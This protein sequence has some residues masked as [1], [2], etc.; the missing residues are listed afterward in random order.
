M[1]DFSIIYGTIVAKKK[2][3]RVKEKKCFDELLGKW[4]TFFQQN[5]A[6]S[7]GD[8]WHFTATS[9]GTIY[10]FGFSVI[11]NPAATLRLF[12]GNAVAECTI[13]KT[14]ALKEMLSDEE[15]MTETLTTATITSDDTHENFFR[16]IGAEDVYKQ[17]LAFIERGKN[18]KPVTE[19]K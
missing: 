15:D 12:C 13:M 6:V 11:E 5:K 14:V 9:D 4:R 10:R 19:E 7:D 8:G 2:D 1:N 18:N 17:A 16:A 3:E